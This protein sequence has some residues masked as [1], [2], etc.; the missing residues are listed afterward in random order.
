MNRRVGI[1]LVANHLLITGTDDLHF[2]YYF[3]WHSSDNPSIWSSV[4]MVSRWL[5]PGN[6]TF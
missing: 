5:L 1:G 6:R 3:R 4:Q 2:N